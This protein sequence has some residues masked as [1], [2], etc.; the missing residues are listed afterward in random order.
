MAV[1]K[2]ALLAI[3]VLAAIAGFLYYSHRHPFVGKDDIPDSVMSY[4]TFLSGTYLCLRPVT[5]NDPHPS[6]CRFALETNEGDYYLL[7]YSYVPTLTNELGNGDTFEARGT[8][9]KKEKLPGVLQKYPV[10]GM[11]YITDSFKKLP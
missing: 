9:T 4:R 5:P 1:N 6:E 11:F 8:V 3:I 2:K 7:N 10:V